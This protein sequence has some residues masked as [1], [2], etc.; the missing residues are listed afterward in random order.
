MSVNQMLHSAQ[1]SQR[2][3]IAGFQKAGTG[4]FAQRL[5]AHE[6][7]SCHWAI[8]ELKYWSRVRGATMAGWPVNWMPAAPVTATGEKS[9]EYVESYRAFEGLRR[10]RVPVIVVLRNPV[11]RLLSHYAWNVRQGL[12][13]RPLLQAVAEEAFAEREPPAGPPYKYRY[14]QRSQYQHWLA[15][16]L[17]YDNL[18][19][20]R[21]EDF[22]DDMTW[23]KVCEFLKLPM[24]KAWQ[25]WLEFRPRQFARHQPTVDL[26]ARLLWFNTKD[27]YD[28]RLLHCGSFEQDYM[29]VPWPEEL[30]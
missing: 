28:V 17:R 13:R 26:L 24:P 30:L 10:N 25:P 3:V 27:H 19:V 29:E 15:P 21:Y 8:P 11:D 14:L 18:L 1:P 4:W 7:A 22:Q 9:S 6:N 20:V 12:E 2:F 5:N 16:W 23:R